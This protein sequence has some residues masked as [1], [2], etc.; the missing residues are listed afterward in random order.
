MKAYC[1][2]LVKADVEQ[3]D[4]NHSGYYG[5]PGNKNTKLGILGDFEF[6]VNYVSMIS[7][8]SF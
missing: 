2:G 5:K 7:R 4:I 8:H 6:V 3:A 1:H